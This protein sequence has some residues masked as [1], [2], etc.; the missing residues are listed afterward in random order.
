MTAQVVSMYDLITISIHGSNLFHTL[1][2]DLEEG[3]FSFQ[4][5]VTPALHLAL[6]MGAST[7]AGILVWSR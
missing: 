6:K 4:V 7:E 5:E 2:G 3:P 1:Q